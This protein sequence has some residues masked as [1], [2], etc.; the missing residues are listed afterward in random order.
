[1]PAA[2]TAGK[3]AA[4]RCRAY[5]EVAGSLLGVHL[6]SRIFGDHVVGDG[7]ALSHLNTCAHDQIS[8][9]QSVGRDGYSARVEC[10]TVHPVHVLHFRGRHR[11]A[12]KTKHRC[13]AGCMPRTR[14]DD[15]IILH[16]R[17]GVQL[18]DLLHAQPMQHIGHQLL[19]AHVLPKA[20]IHRC[21]TSSA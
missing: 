4:R 11:T 3:L 9:G 8:E 16:V 15:R 6:N 5:C 17:H 10:H 19:E 7:D 20:A 18:V 12:L 21:R 1:M 13:A 14:A 2:I